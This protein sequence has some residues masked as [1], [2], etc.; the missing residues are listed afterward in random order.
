MA[1][2]KE[3]ALQLL[4]QIFSALHEKRFA[5]IAALVDESDIVNII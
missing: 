1:F 2:K 5:D 4:G 3:F